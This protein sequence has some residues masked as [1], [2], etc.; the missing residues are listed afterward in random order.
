MRGARQFLARLQG[1]IYNIVLQFT[2]NSEPYNIY[3]LNHLRSLVAMAP[4]CSAASS[5]CVFSRTFARG[6]A[7]YSLAQ[8]QHRAEQKQGRVP[9]KYAFT[10]GKPRGDKKFAECE[11]AWILVDGYGEPMGRLASKIV[12]LLIGKHKPIFAHK[13]DVGDHVIV[14]N[15]AYVLVPQNAL[16]TKKH[17]HHSGWPG[18]LKTKPLYR[19]FEENPTEPLRR[20]I[21]GMMPTNRLRYQRMTRLRLYP[22][23]HHLHEAQL[24]GGD[25]QPKDREWDCRGLGAAHTA[26]ARAARG[27]CGRGAR[28]ALV[29]SAARGAAEHG[30]VEAAE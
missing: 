6:G 24:R 18:G 19:L 21:W 14:V 9:N 15:A 12:Q 13:R 11:R 1:P 26:A 30:P 3:M 2:S 25:A 4:A 20:A 7:T 22:T 5:S 8:H 17:Y 23:A 10:R 28:R 27:R 16:D 29:C